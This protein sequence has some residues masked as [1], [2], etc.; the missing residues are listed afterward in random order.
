MPSLH[1]LVTSTRMTLASTLPHGAAAMQ[2]AVGPFGCASNAVV[3]VPKT[4][5]M[6]LGP[7]SAG[8]EGL[9]A[10]T[11]VVFVAAAAHLRHLGILLSAGS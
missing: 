11:R 8:V 7:G 5:G 6:L 2:L 9:D 1:R 3:S 4:H 10:I